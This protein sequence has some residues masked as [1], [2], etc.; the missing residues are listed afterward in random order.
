MGYVNTQLILALQ[1]TPLDR[2][3]QVRGLTVI[4]AV[5]GLMVSIPAR[6]NDLQMA[7]M[8]A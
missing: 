6:G 7:A 4:P 8:K 1:K 2:V 3:I 5:K